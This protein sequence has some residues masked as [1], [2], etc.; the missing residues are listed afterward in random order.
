[1]SRNS[2]R[3]RIQQPAPPPGPIQSPIPPQP[4]VEQ[5]P[6]G[7]SFVVPTEIV[8]LPSNGA[9]YPEGSP[10]CGISEVEVKAVTSAEEDIMIN[11]SFIE[12]GIV[13]DKLI[14]AILLE[15]R[16]RA[17]DLLDCDKMA[18][19]MSARKTGYGNELDYSYSCEQCGEHQETKILISDLLESAKNKSYQ[20]ASSEEVQYDS[21]SGTFSFTLPQ[22]GLE[23]SIKLLTPQDV[24]ELQEAKKLKEKLNLPFNE[25]IEFIRKVVVQAAN[26]TDR[27]NI[28]KL[29]EILPAIDA[30][31]IRMVHNSN[32]PKINTTNQLVCSSCG[33]QTEKEVP[34]SL[35]WFWPN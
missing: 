24:S 35:G 15:P 22:T 27:T 21:S 4:K 11:D 28:N 33:H 14:E 16:V 3:T 23:V 13:F 2:K 18:I 12:R 20:P 30:R 25:T 32:I 31:K 8:H 26:V 5:N 34:F 10:L 29:S 7:L 19:L 6:F 17:S 9:L 1:M